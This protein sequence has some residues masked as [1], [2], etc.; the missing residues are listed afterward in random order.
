VALQPRLV[1]AVANGLVYVPVLATANFW[2]N[3]NSFVVRL[4]DISDLQNGAHTLLSHLDW[5]DNRIIKV[6]VHFTPVSA[7]SGPIY[8]M[9]PADSE[10]VRTKTNCS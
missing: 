1:A 4:E 2:Y 9:S 3:P 8:I 5:E 10:Y 7:S 6:I